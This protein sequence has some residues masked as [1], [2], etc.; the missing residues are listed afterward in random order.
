MTKK[1]PLSTDD[2]L[3]YL[4]VKP[5]HPDGDKVTRAEAAKEIRRLREE[6]KLAKDTAKTL[7]DTRMWGD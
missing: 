1:S 3:K 5:G 2:I 6:L 4:D 7:L